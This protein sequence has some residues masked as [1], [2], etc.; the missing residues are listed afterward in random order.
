MVTGGSDGGVRLTSIK[1]G[2]L[3]TVLSQSSS[4]VYQVKIAGMRV[5]ATAG[6]KVTVQTV[7]LTEGEPESSLSH[8]LEGHTRDVLCLD[9][10]GDL[11]VTG[12]TDKLVLV[13]KLGPAGVYKVIH[14]LTEHKLKVSCSLAVLNLA[15]LLLQN[16]KQTLLGGKWSLHDIMTFARL[17]H[18]FIN[19]AHSLSNLG[20]TQAIY[21][22]PDI[23]M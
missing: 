4:Y 11:I 6:S 9:I 16:R 13:Y 2:H 5:V 15:N 23:L 8:L 7:Q 12:G 18:C 22:S 1:T 10:C 14:T 3:L 20:S 21:K 19:N 17:D